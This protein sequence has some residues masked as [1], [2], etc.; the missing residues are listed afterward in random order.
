MLDMLVKKSYDKGIKKLVGYYYPT[1][2]NKMVSELYKDFGFEKIS[3][4]E[5]GNTEWVLD[6]HLYKQKNKVI[7]VKE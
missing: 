2:K 3:E 4:D 1:A 6:T 7:E 5:N